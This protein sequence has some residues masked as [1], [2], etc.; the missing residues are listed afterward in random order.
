MNEVEIENEI[1]AKGLNAPRL[2]PAD[3]DNAI[4][5]ADYYVFPGTTLKERKDA[6]RPRRS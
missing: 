3:I 1:N 2:S 4:V 6:R 5:G